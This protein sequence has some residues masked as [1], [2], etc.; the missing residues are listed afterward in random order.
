MPGQ[1]SQPEGR[2]PTAQPLPPE[3][4]QI[5]R[6]DNHPEHISHVVER[7]HTPGVALRDTV[8]FPNSVAVGVLAGNGGGGGGGCGGGAGGP[9][10]GCGDHQATFGRRQQDTAE[11][12]LW[13]CCMP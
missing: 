2:G 10:G 12:W 4:G 11:K 6:A 7:K 13:P 9:A 3:V 1:S 5:Y 8:E